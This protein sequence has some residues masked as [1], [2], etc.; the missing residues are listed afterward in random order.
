M[1]ER[2]CG[3]QCSREASSKCCGIP[4][5]TRLEAAALVRRMRAATKRTSVAATATLRAEF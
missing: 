4:V 3:D 2:V 5:N 1:S